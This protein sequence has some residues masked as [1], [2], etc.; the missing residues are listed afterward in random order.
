[1]Y[2]RKRNLILAFLLFTVSCIAGPVSKYPKEK[3]AQFVIENLDVTSFPSSIGPRMSPGKTFFQDYGFVPRIVKDSEALL[4]EADGS[5][6]FH[7]RVLD[8]TDSGI[9]VCF[10]DQAANGGTYHTQ[11]VLYLVRSDNKS[12]LKSTGVSGR[13]RDDHR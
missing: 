5:W 7:I 9:F 13:G 11:D 1:M 2:K 10:E 4:E 12:P 8:R 3:L 6:R